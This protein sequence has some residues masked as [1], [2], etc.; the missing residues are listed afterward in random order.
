[1]RRLTIK[2]KMARRLKHSM[3]GFWPSSLGLAMIVAAWAG[4]SLSGQG[5]TT[6]TKGEATGLSAVPAQALRG[7]VICLAEE[8]H[9]TYGT[10]LPTKHP[11]LYGFK[12]NDGE[13]IHL[14]ANEAF[15][16]H[17]RGS[18]GSGTRAYVVGASYPEKPGDRCGDHQ[19]GQGWRG[20]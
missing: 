20:A 18:A 10:H 2:S 7:R 15:R 16:G 9:A 17:L 4:A 12:T 5:E 8:M 13:D 14:A 3:K 19:V 11:H 6:A 1:M